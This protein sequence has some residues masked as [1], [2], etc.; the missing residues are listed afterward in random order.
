M[1]TPAIHRVVEETMTDEEIYARALR[2]QRELQAHSDKLREEALAARVA[3]QRERD[4]ANAQQIFHQIIS[5]IEANPALA[6]QLR[7]ALGITE[8]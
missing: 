4:R 2:V 8:E 1:T 6:N 3:E 5:A 7:A